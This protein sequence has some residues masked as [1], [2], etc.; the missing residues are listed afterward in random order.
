[1]QKTLRKIASASC[2]A[3]GCAKYGVATA[4]RGYEVSE[5]GSGGAVPDGAEC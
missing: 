5:Y 3:V 4:G 1:M 2:R